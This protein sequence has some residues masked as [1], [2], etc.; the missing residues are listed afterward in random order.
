M[1]RRALKVEVSIFAPV[2]MNASMEDGLRPSVDQTPPDL[3]YERYEQGFER[4]VEFMRRDMPP[5]VEVNEDHAGKRW[6]AE[7]GAWCL[8][9]KF[10]AR[11]SWLCYKHWREQQTAYQRD[12]R[13]NKRRMKRGRGE[14]KS[15]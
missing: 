10:G 4:A 2:A 6:C 15:A 3:L 11:C 1:K 12:Y 14:S 13:L 8:E 7:C 9:S 5:L